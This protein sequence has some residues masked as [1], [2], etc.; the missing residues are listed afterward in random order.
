MIFVD[1]KEII[2]ISADL[3]SGIHGSIYLKLR[4]IRKVCGQ[5]AG[6]DQDMSEDT[7]AAVRCGVEALKLIIAQDKQT[8]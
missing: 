2:E 6:L 3:L 1:H 4:A 7:S 5:A 8:F